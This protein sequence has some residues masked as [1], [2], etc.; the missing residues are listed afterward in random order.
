MRVDLVAEHG[1][2][3][4][5][6]QQLAAEWIHH[7]HGVLPD[8]PDDWMVESF[9]G[10]QLAEQDALVDQ[11]DRRNSIHEQLVV[12]K[13]ELAWVGDDA[14]KSLRG[15]VLLEKPELAVGGHFMPI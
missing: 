2:A 10:D 4:L 14:F 1:K 6:M 12:A 11:M 8:C 3:G 9:A 15:E 7:A 5:L 13:L